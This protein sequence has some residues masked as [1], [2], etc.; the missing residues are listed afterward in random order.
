MSSLSYELIRGEVAPCTKID[1]CKM[2]LSVMISSCNLAGALSTT[3]F[4]F[5]TIG[6]ACFP[7]NYYNYEHFSLFSGF[8]LRSRSTTPRS[9]SE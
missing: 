4:S 3:K 5:L 9:T 1:C 2:V 8:T 6:Y 7:N